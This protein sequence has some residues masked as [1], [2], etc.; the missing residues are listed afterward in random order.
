MKTFAVMAVIF[1][2]FAIL[3]PKI[4]H[5]IVLS[6]LGISSPS[7]QTA[8]TGTCMLIGSKLKVWSMVLFSCYI[9][10]SASEFRHPSEVR[11]SYFMTVLKLLYY[12]LPANNYTLLSKGSIPLFKVWIWSH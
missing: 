12:D 6:A 3:Y 4:F 7:T 2:C 5:P 9:Y 10:W 8:D 11:H 1:G